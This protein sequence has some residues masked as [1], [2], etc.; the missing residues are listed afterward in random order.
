V[1]RR[2]RALIDPSNMPMLRCKDD[3]EIVQGLSHHFCPIIDNLSRLPEWL[4]DTLSRAVTGE[5]FTKRALYTNADDYIFA[6][7]RVF[8]LTGIGLVLTKPDLLDRSIIIPLERIPDN[9]RRPEQVLNEEFEAARPRL[10]GAMLEMM[11]G[12]IRE[13]RNV[14]VAKL[15]RMADFA[16]WAMAVSLGEGRDPEQFV[17]A[18]AANVSRQ[19]DE[20]LNASTVAIVLMTFL[21]DCTNWTGQPH[22]LYASLKQKAEELKIPAKSFPGS[23]SAMG[24]QLREI[25]PNLTAVGWQIDFGASS[26]ERRIVINRNYSENTVPTVPAVTGSDSK[27]GKNGIFPLLNADPWE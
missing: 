2:L 12:A 19:N 11:A 4:S 20:A 23:A 16:K 22:E 14:E 9:Q 6:Y 3:A 10:F 21:G 5:G 26:G 24:R 15:P 8:V 1:G 27:N 7:K 25:R 18:F 13:Q 17:S